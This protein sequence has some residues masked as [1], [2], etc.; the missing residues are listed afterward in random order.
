MKDGDDQSA[1][2]HQI[3]AGLTAK[4]MRTSSGSTS[5]INVF[6]VVLIWHKSELP[7]R[8][9]DSIFHFLSL[10]RHHCFQKYKIRVT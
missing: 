1:L 10:L 7:A 9:L 3:T 2:C 8:I 6:D 4:T 5:D